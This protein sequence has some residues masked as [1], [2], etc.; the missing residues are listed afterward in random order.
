MERHQDLEAALR[1]RIRDE[2]NLHGRK[3]R[4]TDSL[5]DHLERVAQIAVTLGRGEGVTPE[6]CRL[7]GLFH[8]AG[9]FSC[10]CY[11]EDGTVEEQLSVGVLRQMAAQHGVEPQ[12]VDQVAEAILQLYRDDP[13]PGPLARVLFD[14]DNLDKLGP[15][16]VANLFVKTGLRGRGVSQRVLYSLTIELTYARYAERCMMTAI[17][18][19]RAAVRAEY[20]TRFLLEFLET[21]REDG[22]YDFR[23]EDV[24]FDGLVLQ[25]VAPSACS[26]GGRLERRLWPEQGIKCSEIHLEHRCTKCDDGQKLRFCRPKLA[27]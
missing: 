3:D 22:M 10:G 24:E 19:Q 16:G 12:V 5:W 6:A 8:D 15:L 2:E 1:H 13:S 27:L 21:L 4:R 26:C 20:T 14:A 25:V 17:G 9:K 7:A 23:V 18:R 11:H